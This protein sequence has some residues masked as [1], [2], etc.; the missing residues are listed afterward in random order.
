MILA[1]IERQ[2]REALKAE[3]AQ[4]QCGEEPKD[5]LRQIADE[6][7]WLERDRLDAEM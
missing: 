3:A 1:E 2:F 7:E 6:L 4:R 5:L